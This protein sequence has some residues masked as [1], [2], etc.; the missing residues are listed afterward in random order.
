MRLLGAR[1]PSWTAVG[2]AKKAAGAG[3]G[4]AKG[5]GPFPP[6]TRRPPHLLLCPHFLESGDCHIYRCENCHSEVRWA[7]RGRGA[8]WPRF[9]TRNRRLCATT[10]LPCPSSPPARLTPLCRFAAPQE[11]QRQREQEWA[12]RQEGERREARRRELEAAEAAQARR[13]EE[14]EVLA[15]LVGGAAPMRPC[16]ALSCA[17]L[18]S[19]ESP[20]RRRPA[21]VARRGPTP[22]CRPAPLQESLEMHQRQH[23]APAPAPAPRAP[24]A[25]AAAPAAQRPPLQLSPRAL[26]L[27]RAFKRSH[28]LNSLLEMGFATERAQAATDAAGGDAAAA[29][30]L[31]MDGARCGGAREVD[32]ARWGGSVYVGG[33][34]WGECRGGR[35]QRQRVAERV[36]V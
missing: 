16:C 4:G 35:R 3:P 29:V 21:A 9:A 32:V 34:G 17:P 10:Q 31:L 15:Q 23:L 36:C 19:C 14:A 24:W 30:Q 20:A 5:A 11:E 26:G 33:G 18:C 13:E 6:G 28:C 7:V 1:Q 12:A 8:G 27:L 25:A 22:C 2:G